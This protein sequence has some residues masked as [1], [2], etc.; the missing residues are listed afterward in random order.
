S[1]AELLITARELRE[2]IEGIP[3]VLEVL[4][5]GEREDLLEIVVDPLVLESYGL[6]FDTLFSL[7]SRNNRLVA[8]GSLDTGAGRMALK[9]PGVIETLEDVLSIPVKVDGDSVV[10]FADVASIRRTFK[11]PQGFARING[12]PA[13]VL[14]VSKR[15][16]ANIINTIDGVKYLLEQAA[17]LR[18]DGLQID[19]IMDQSE[20]VDDLLSELLNNVI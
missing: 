5:G 7:I 13:V 17:P 15:A 18:P 4:I 11:D 8:A 20:Q 16:G 9:V 10:T 6:N 3:D 12:R 2:A 1:E 19:L 14:E